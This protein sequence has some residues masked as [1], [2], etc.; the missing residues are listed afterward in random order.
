MKK[1][2]KDVLLSIGHNYLWENLKYRIFRGSK[3][4]LLYSSMFSES[5]ATAEFS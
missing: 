3:S 1:M 5:K 4:K 2:G